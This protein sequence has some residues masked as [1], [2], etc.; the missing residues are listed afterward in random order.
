MKEKNQKMPE[1]VRGA[2]EIAIYLAA[3][4]LMFYGAE[5]IKDS[6]NRLTDAKRNKL[7]VPALTSQC[8]LT[9]P[10]DMGCNRQVTRE[11]CD[12]NN[13][14]FDKTDDVCETITYWDYIPVVNIYR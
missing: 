9:D 4:G 8:S 7:A 13:T 2:I 10:L 12:G 14:I 3:L 1:R 6:E 5:Q 11:L